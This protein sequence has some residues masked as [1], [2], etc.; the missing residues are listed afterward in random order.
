MIELRTLRP[1]DIETVVKSVRK[2]NRLLIVHEAWVKGGF[3]AE[4]AAMVADKAFD[5]LDAP[6]TRSGGSDVPLPYAANLESQ[7]LPQA[8]DIAAAARELC[9]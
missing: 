8:D 2:T 9:S 4:V 3:G 1:L 7:A 6:I 5:Y